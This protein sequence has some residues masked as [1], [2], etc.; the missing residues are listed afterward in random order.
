MTLRGGDVWI[1]RSIGSNLAP[2]VGTYGWMTHIH[3]LGH[4]LGLKHS[5]Q[6]SQYN[7]NTVPSST[8]DIEFTVMSYRSFI[9]A[10]LNG[11]TNETY[12]YAQT[13]MMYDIAALQTMYG[14]DFSTNS[15][16]TRYQWDPSTGTMYLNGVSQGT[17]GA[18]RIFLTTWDGGGNDTYDLWAPRIIAPLT[19]VCE[20]RS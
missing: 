10:P 11:Y 5:H 6:G 8:D 16:D 1:G 9:N 20:S 14:A 12:G 2:I 15:S 18:N 17:P 13:L 7:G 19:D 3:E 4:A